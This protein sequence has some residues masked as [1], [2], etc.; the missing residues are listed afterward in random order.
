TPPVQPPPAVAPVAANGTPPAAA[1]G[2]PQ[3]GMQVAVGPQGQGPEGTPPGSVPGGDAVAAS[4]TDSPH[5]DEGTEE[6]PPRKPV[7]KP[8]VKERV[9]LGI[10]DIQRVVSNGRS[11]ITGCFERYKSDL[12]SAAGE[13]QV[14]LTI[15]SSGK[16]RAGTRGPLASTAVGR[17]LET[18]AQG[19]RFPAHRDQEV[20]VL[21]PFSW[22]VTQ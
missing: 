11:K 2:S 18:Q 20:T 6:T 14:Q 16:V 22:K 3:P 13:V 5:V 1:Q 10:E 19:L 7:T 4:V 12:P 17:C 15:V 8:A 9:S 21:M